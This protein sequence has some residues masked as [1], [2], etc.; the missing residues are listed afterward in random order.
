VSDFNLRALVR[1]V[2]DE[3]G[4]ADPTVLA[5]AVYKRVAAKDRPAALR[6]ALRHF[7]RL[8][9]SIDRM[10][11]AVQER[12]DDKPAGRSWKRDGIRQGWRAHLRQR[13]H[14]ADGWKFLGDCGFDDLMF[15]AAERRE[16][17]SR[18][19][20]AADR[21]EALAKLLANHNVTRVAD[22]PDEVLDEIE[23]DDEGEAA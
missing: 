22:L 12:S 4:A 6:E 3:S 5:D 18:T 8:N 14:V 7:V 20:A 11:P 23:T 13:L 16:I 15:A 2:S 10:T 9:V 1:E 19:M 17:A 21:Y